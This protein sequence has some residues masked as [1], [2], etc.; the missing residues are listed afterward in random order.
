VI[1]FNSEDRA[2]GRR[3]RSLLSL[4]EETTETASS[5]EAPQ[6]KQKITKRSKQ[7]ASPAKAESSTA[8][9]A[10]KSVEQRVREAMNKIETATRRGDD[11]AASPSPASKSPASAT[12]PDSSTDRA[13]AQPRPA[14]ATPQPSPEPVLPPV[15][16]NEHLLVNVLPNGRLSIQ[17][18]DSTS[19]PP[20]P[21][22]HPF[23]RSSISTN[24]TST[25]PGGMVFHHLNK[26]EDGPDMGDEYVFKRV[27]SHRPYYFYYCYFNYYLFCLLTCSELNREATRASCS[28]ARRTPRSFVSDTLPR[29]QSFR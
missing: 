14:A 15:M 26:L 27:R 28:P 7:S 23:T 1:R 5:Q 22:N 21:L 29:T 6:R 2:G 12:V 8:E 19:A 24:P 10:T 3:K 13:L 16:E 9:Q 20:H 25:P 11:G 17:H 18:K 4:E